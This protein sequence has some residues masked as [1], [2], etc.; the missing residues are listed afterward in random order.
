MEEYQDKKK[1]YLRFDFPSTN[2]IF[3]RGNDSRRFHSTLSHFKHFML[4]L[5]AQKSFPRKNHF[6][7]ELSDQIIFYKDK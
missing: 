5:N 1:L 4:L 3:L 6:T 2:K 7:Q